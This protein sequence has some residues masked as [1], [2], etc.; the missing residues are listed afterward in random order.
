MLRF[1]STVLAGFALTHSLLGAEL[2]R[3][4]NF[5]VVTEDHPDSA[6]TDESF[7]RS[8]LQQAERYRAEIARQWL[9]RPLPEG[10]GRTIINVTFSTDHDRGLTWAMD[11][12]ERRFHNIYLNTQPDRAIESTLA[13]EIAHTVLATRYPHPRRLPEWIE[14][15]IA[16]SYDDEQRRAQRRELVAWWMETDSVP[17]LEKLLTLRAVSAEDATAYTA[18]SSLVDYLLTKQDRATLL[19]FAEEGVRSG[20]DRALQIHYGLAS[21]SA[22]QT[23][24]IQWLKAPPQLDALAQRR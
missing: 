17:S 4:A 21:V 1:F 12:S 7:A 14:E 23:T 13:H 22:L 20:W 2:V 11:G 3:N 18:A 5:L 24:W 8:V 6:A 9:G 19:R 15:G 16:S 10:V